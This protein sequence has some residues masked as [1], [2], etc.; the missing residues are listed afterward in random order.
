M[1]MARVGIRDRPR[2]VSRAELRS[3][4]VLVLVEED[5]DDDEDE[6]KMEVMGRRSATEGSCWEAT[7]ESWVRAGGRGSREGGAGSTAVRGG[8]VGLTAVREGG[9]GSTAVREGFTAAGWEEPPCCSWLPAE[10]GRAELSVASGK[11]LA[12]G[13]L[14]APGTE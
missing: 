10:P 1:E 8:G 4:V 14:L 13:G 3:K 5:E 7:E 11:K 2:A 9:A 6:E 12:E